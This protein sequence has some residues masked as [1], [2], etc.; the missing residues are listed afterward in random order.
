[1]KA[2]NFIITGRRHRQTR[3]TQHLGTFQSDPRQLP[4]WP[5][6]M[7]VNCMGGHLTDGIRQDN[8]G[9]VMIKVCI[10]CAA[11]SG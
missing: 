10:C 9:Q 1:M 7:A 4:Q 2:T 6:R 5:S 11:R 3:N 8:G